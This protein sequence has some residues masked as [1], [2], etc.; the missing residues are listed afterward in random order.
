[1]VENFDVLVLEYVA[2]VLAGEYKGGDTE[3][4]EREEEGR[5]I[6]LAGRRENWTCIGRS[7]W[8]ISEE[9]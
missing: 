7:G 1:M 6:H 2:A 8:K 4:E 9:K 3:G 5:S